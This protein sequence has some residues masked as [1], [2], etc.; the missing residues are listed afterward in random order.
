MTRRSTS[1]PA[2]RGG[3]LGEVGGLRGEPVSSTRMTAAASAIDP[4]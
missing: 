4:G 3:D 1:V 2:E